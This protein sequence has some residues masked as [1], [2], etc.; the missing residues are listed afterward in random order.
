MDGK[1]KPSKLHKER[2]K[3]LLKETNGNRRKHNTKK[4]NLRVKRVDD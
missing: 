2:I 1:L 3:K 4:A